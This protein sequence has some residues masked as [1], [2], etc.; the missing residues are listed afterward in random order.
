MISVVIPCFNEEDCISATLP[1]IVSEIRAIAR[2]WQL[3][4]VDDGS[5]DSTLN[6][7][8]SIKR[9]LNLVQGEEI[10]IISLRKNYGHMQ[11]LRAGIAASK[12]EWTVTMDVD[13]QD[14]PS[15]IKDLILEAEK[16]GA[17]LVMAKRETR[18]EDS[19]FKRFTANAYYR[20]IRFL[21]G[22][23]ITPNVADFRLMHRC[24]IDWINSNEE[25]RLVFRLILMAQGFKT[26]FVLFHRPARVHGTTKYSLAK[27]TNLA[28]DSAVTFGIKP[29]RI[30]GI[31]GFTLGVI[32]FLIGV[33]EIIIFAQGKS[34]PGV[35][36][37]LLPMLFLNA[38]ILIAIGLIGEYLGV[39]LQELR[40]R[41]HYVVES[42]SRQINRIT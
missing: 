21:A 39:I 25:E 17:C 38:F 13:L 26:S 42:C 22:K 1:I 19:L 35:P 15:L 10:E 37:I 24:V 7:M 32:A 40:K 33:A 34:I 20:L 27:M 5:Q 4:L 36:S 14:P 16:S 29:L 8:G 9:S 30:C 6:L 12:H 23:E 2:V 18:D 28:I 41:N 31:V 3:I 11:A